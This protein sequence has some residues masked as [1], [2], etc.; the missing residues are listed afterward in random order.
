MKA[1]RWAMSLGVSA[2]LGA[3]AGVGVIARAGDAAEGEG[4]PKQRVDQ[5]APLEIAVLDDVVPPAFGIGVASRSR[6]SRERSA[7]IS[8]CT[9]T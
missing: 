3:A 1:A 9:K 5:R 4:L 8:R 7:T 6:E 2:M